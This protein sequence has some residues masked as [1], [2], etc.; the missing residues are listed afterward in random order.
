MLCSTLSC[1]LRWEETKHPLQVCCSPI[2]AMQEHMAV[3]AAPR[4]A[5]G[6]LANPWRPI[7]SVHFV[8]AGSCCNMRL[9]YLMAAARWH[10]FVVKFPG[11]AAELRLPPRGDLAASWSLRRG[12]L[13]AMAPDAARPLAARRR[14]RGWQRNRIWS[15]VV[16]D[17]YSLRTGRGDCRSQHSSNSVCGNVSSCDGKS[18]LRFVPPGSQGGGGVGGTT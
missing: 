1:S 18:V 5:S 15:E 3:V 12:L 2:R 17:I 4:V 14:G 11:L 9:L 16:L 13:C 8:S 7:A 6:E 10:M